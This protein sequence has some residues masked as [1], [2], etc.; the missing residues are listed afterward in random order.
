MELAKKISG[1]FIVFTLVMLCMVVAVNADTGLVTPDVGLNLRTGAGTDYD[2]ID[3]IPQGTILHIIG[4]DN[5]WLQVIYRDK[6]GYVSQEYVSLQDDMSGYG[7]SV[8]AEMPLREQVVEYAK[9]F[10]GTP[11]VY[12]GS[13]PGGFDCSGFTSYVYKQFGYTINRVAADQASNGVAVDRS[14][15]LPGDLVFF[16][17][18]GYGIGHVGIYV[19]D[20]QIIHS[21]KPGDFIRYDSLDTAYYANNYVCAR[22]II[23]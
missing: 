19:G 3:V 4:Y 1:M 9:Q 17:N 20:G 2:I 5:G 16:T 15:L 21:P 13:A 8:D 7:S 14:A 22:R 10:L 23:Y 18:G 6:T 12:G 11:Y